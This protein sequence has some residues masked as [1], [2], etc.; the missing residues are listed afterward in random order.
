MIMNEPK[1]KRLSLRTS[2]GELEWELLY[3]TI[4][5]KDEDNCLHCTFRLRPLPEF[6]YMT[7]ASYCLSLDVEGG[8]T[9]NEKSLVLNEDYVFRIVPRSFHRP[10]GEN[11]TITIVIL[12]KA[13]ELTTVSNSNRLFNSSELSDVTLKCGDL[14]IPAHKSILATHSETWRTAFASSD[15]FAEGRSSVYDISSENMDPDI[16]TDVVR[17]IYLQN[18]DNIADNLADLLD[19]AEYFQI[20][21]LKDICSRMLIKKLTV[22]SCLELLDTAYKYD[23]K[24]LK[25]SVADPGCFIPDPDPTIAPSRI[26]IP[27]PRGK[28]APDPGSDLFFLQ[29]LFTYPGSGSDH[30]SIPDPRSRSRIRGVKK[31]RIPDPDPQHYSRD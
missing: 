13:G 19:A 14:K 24:K 22:E 5:K 29:I 7:T 25:S 27:D 30:C 2:G 4:L 1:P 15:S 23:L 8:D 10:L 28:K 11:L 20:A 16:L 21:S 3:N 18:I 9:A 6:F 26:R 31:H 12:L 17:W